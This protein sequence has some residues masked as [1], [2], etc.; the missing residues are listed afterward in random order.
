[1]EERSKCHPL[2]PKP[3]GCQANFLV[4]VAPDTFCPVDAI[5]LCGVQYPANALFAGLGRVSVCIQTYLPSSDLPTASKTPHD[6]LKNLDALSK[7]AGGFLFL[8][9]RLVRRQTCSDEDR[10]IP[11]ADLLR[12]AACSDLAGSNGLPLH[13]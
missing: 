12:V 6:P 13:R 1:M 3:K 4:S 5:S 2:G 11:C 9:W 10:D 8:C 7:R